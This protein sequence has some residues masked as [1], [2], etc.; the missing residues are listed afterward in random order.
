MVIEPVDEPHPMLS[1]S[2]SS[3]ACVASGTR[4]VGKGTYAQRL[5]GRGRD[6]RIELV[7]RRVGGEM[8]SLRSKH[9]QTDGRVARVECEVPRWTVEGEGVEGRARGGGEGSSRR[10]HAHEGEGEQTGGEPA[11]YKH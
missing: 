11:E 6:I 3:P 9:G 10:H 7:R 2:M 1:P 4:T 5:T 8:D